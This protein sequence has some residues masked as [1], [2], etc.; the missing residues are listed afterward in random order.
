MTKF[1]LLGHGL[2]TV[3]VR[4]V[5]I[6]QQSSALA[7]HHQQPAART[8]IL[9][10][11]LQMLGQ[12]VD[13]LCEQGY[14]HVCGSSITLVKFEWFDGLRFGFHTFVNSCVLSLKC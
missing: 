9:L 14:L 6:I 8:V 13:A 4:V 1:E 3:D 5:Q 10:V 2:I 12:M 7:D 11:A